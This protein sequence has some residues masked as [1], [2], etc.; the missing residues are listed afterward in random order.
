MNEEMEE[1]I[2]FELYKSHICHRVK[3]E[4]DLSF[5]RNVLLSDEIRILYNRGW[6]PES[7]YLLAMVDYLSRIHNVPLY[8]AYEYL[9]Y[10]QLSK[11]LYPAGIRVLCIASENEEYKEE[12]LKECIPE[13]LRHNIVEAEIRNVC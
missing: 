1:R 9:R 11:I 6:H 4:G 12:S 2:D 3:R 8:N 7:L 5:I 10:A 13:F